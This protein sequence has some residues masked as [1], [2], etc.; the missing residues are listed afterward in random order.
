MRFNQHSELKDQHA[1]L[2][3][4]QY[5]WI[6]YSDE[7]LL[8]RYA[9]HRNAVRGTEL[10]ELAHRC[11]KLGIK[12]RETGQTFNMYVNDCIGYGMETEQVLFVS[13]KA[14]GTADAIG[15]SDKVL[16]I[17]DLKNGVTKASGDQ[18]K[19]YAAFFCIEYKVR[20]MEIGFDL[21]IYQND[22]IFQIEVDPE[23]IVYIMS[24]VQEF[25]KMLQAAEEALI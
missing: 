5:H 6:R 20:P 21:R 15:F 14:F 25:D 13:Y 16:R 23:E 17:F 9:N 19:V 4:S 11:I 7:K 3:A 8:E 2:S 24:R 1:F 22:E 18:L 10:H 12:Q